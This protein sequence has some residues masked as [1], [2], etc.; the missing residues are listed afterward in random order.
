MS[1]LKFRCITFSPSGLVYPYY[2]ETCSI[3]GLAIALK[4]FLMIIAAVSAL[5]FLSNAGSG[6][7]VFKVSA[8]TAVSPW[9]NGVLLMLGSFLVHPLIL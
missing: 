5:S 2:H 1:A 9:L 3:I 8:I 4:A 7:F 6:Y